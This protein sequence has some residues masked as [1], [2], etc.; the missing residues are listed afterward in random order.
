MSITREGT[1]SGPHSPA[2]PRVRPRLGT[3]RMDAPVGAWVW[4]HLAV[5][6]RLTRAWPSRDH[7]LT[8]RG[9][10]IAD[11]ATRLSDIAVP[12]YSPDLFGRVASVP[13]M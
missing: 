13:K 6:G 11:G 4:R 10:A 2:V 1:A 7:V 9:V 12:R 5:R 3:D 8:P